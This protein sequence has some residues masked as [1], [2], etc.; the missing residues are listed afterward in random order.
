MGR[1]QKRKGAQGE[2]EWCDVLRAH[3]VAAKR[4]LGQ[5]R[6]GGS[7]VASRPFDWEVKRRRQRLAL[8]AWVEQAQ[9][10]SKRT[11]LAVRSDNE[12]WLV[13]LTTEQFFSLLDRGGPRG[14]GRGKNT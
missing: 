7:D 14:E 12:Q 9:A 10:A 13:I 8:Y 6:D 3:G 5:A 1:M 2:R 4:K 11:A